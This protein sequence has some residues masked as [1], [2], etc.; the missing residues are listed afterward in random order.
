MTDSVG[1]HPSVCLI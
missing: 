1:N